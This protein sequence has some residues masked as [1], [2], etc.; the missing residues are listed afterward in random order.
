[1][2]SRTFRP[3]ETVYCRFTGEAFTVV[4]CN[5]CVVFVI[6]GAGNTTGR[7]IGE[8]TRAVPHPPLLRDPTIRPTTA[9]LAILFSLLVAP[10]VAFLSTLVW[11]L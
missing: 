4:S 8:L 2:S 1:M 7:I 3:N 9:I 10:Y 11:P 6:D 5:G